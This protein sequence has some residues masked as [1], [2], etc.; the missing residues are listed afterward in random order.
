V[1]GD[2]RTRRVVA[3]VLS[4]LVLLLGLYAV[5]GSSRSPSPATVTAVLADGTPAAHRALDPGP[6]PRLTRHAPGKPLLSWATLLAAIAGGVALRRWSS[7]TRAGAAPA[8]RG[9][10]TRDSRAPPLLPRCTAQG[11]WSSG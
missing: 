9:R 8:A 10:F 6:Q 4:A 1:V 7:P 2:G 11:R 3:G 5:L